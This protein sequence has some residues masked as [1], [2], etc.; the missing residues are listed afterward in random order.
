[1]KHIREHYL[2]IVSVF[3]WGNDYG[4]LGMDYGTGCGGRE[5]TALIPFSTAGATA[6]AG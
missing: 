2:N 3:R 1:M 4:C 5:P 6:D